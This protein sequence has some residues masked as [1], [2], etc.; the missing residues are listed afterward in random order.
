[1]TEA[2]VLIEFFLPKAGRDSVFRALI[3]NSIPKKVVYMGV[4]LKTK[5][6]PS[7]D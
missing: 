3:F 4:M 1:M 2:N 7:P 5:S 6:S